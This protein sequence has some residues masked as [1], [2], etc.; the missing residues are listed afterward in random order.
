MDPS[1]AK[2]ILANAV[3]HVSLSVKIWLKAKDLEVEAKSQKRVLRRALEYI[4]NSVVLWKAAI[5]CEEESDDAR[6]L[7]SRAVECVPTSVE[8]WLALARLESYSNAEKIMNK[9]R[10][11]NPN[12]VEVWLAAA[13]LQEQNSN[14][15]RV[16]IAIK[17]AVEKKL[18][19]REQWLKQAEIC[20]KE[21][22][23]TVLRTIIRCSVS[24]DLEEE[25]ILDTFLDDAETCIK[26]GSFQ[27][28]RAI[29]EHALSIFPEEVSIWQDAAFMEKAHGSSASL[30]HLLI[31]AVAQ[32]PNAE[33]MWLMYAKEKWIAGDVNAA[34]SLL[35]RA[36]VAM[37]NSEEIWLAAIKLEVETKEYQKA[38]ELLSQARLKAGTERV[39]M[40]STVLERLLKNYSTAFQ[41]LDQA[42]EKFPTFIKLWAIKG[43]IY[44]NDLKDNLKAREHYA[45]AVKRLPKAILLWILASRAEEKAGTSIKARAILEKARILNPKNSDLWTEAVQV[46][47]R[48]GNSSMAKALISKALQECPASGSLWCEMILMENRPQRKARSS[49]ALKHC[50]N[51]PN[52]VTTVARLF[53]AERRIDTARKWFLRSI[54]TN[55]DLGDSWAWWLQFESQHGSQEERNLVVDRCIAADP[56][57]GVEWQKVAKKLENTGLKPGEILK[58]VSANLKNEFK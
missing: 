9:A 12:S 31:K 52:V 36:F 24:L 32:C 26:N 51:D 10:K 29:Y 50:E 44:H 23:L 28:A 2:V 55:S 43:Q 49:D 22:F 46:E 21:G 30:E 13:K 54:K 41:L 8:L 19:D 40:K 38:R 53:W 1:Q 35:E 15:D 5:S 14:V 39:W 48:G 3:R 58:I 11:A 20:E 45:I 56:K 42:L 57:H 17:K 7:L 47:R 37:P 34:K 27:T 18:L 4:P 6:I 25:E 16:T 33:M